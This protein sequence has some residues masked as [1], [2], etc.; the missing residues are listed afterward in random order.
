MSRTI[1]RKNQETPDVYKKFTLLSETDERSG[2][3]WGYVK[4]AGDELKE[5]I[6]KFHQEGNFTYGWS[7]PKV[8]RKM[9]TAKQRMHDK[10]ELHHFV[11]TSDYEPMVLSKL[12]MG[13]WT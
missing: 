11:K 8:H 12:R 7:A 6:R 3:N 10:T 4:L 9:T 13:Y 1:R 2:W 5:S